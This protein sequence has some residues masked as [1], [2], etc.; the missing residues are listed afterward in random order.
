MLK[1]SL[2][3]TQIVLLV[4]GLAF[5]LGT[6]DTYLTLYIAQAP[7]PP[8]ELHACGPPGEN[9]LSRTQPASVVLEK[10]SHSPFQPEL[11]VTSCARRRAARR[12]FL[13]ATLPPK[14][15]PLYRG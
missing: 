1:M 7:P 5:I 2:P 4:V 10:D 3:R 9:A 6:G 11:Q 12:V 14:C 8:R 15:D 13:C